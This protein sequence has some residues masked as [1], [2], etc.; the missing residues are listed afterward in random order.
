MSS[1]VLFEEVRVRRAWNR[2]EQKWDFAIA[3]VFE[4][5]FQATIRAK[6]HAP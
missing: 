2:A 6:P 4:H 3:A 5:R 1:I